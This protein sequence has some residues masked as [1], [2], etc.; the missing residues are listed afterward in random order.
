MLSRR[1][2]ARLTLWIFLFGLVVTTAGAYVRLSDA[3]LGCPDWPGCYGHVGV[4]ERAEDIARANQ[5]FERPVEIEKGWKEMYHRYIAGGLGL[6]ILAQAILAGAIRRRDPYQ[7]V[8]LPWLL[9]G[10]V[11]FQ[12]LLGMWTV[13]LQLKPLVVTGHLLMGFTTVA[14]LWWLSL[15]SGGRFLRSSTPPMGPGPRALALFALVVVFAQIALGGWVASNYAA[16]AC[17]DFPTCHGSWWPEADF[18]SAFVLWHGLGINYEYGILDAPARIA[19]QLV[20]RV[21]AVVTVLTVVATALVFITRHPAH[22]AARIALFS[23]AIVA[24]QFALGVANVLLSLPLHVAVAHNLVGALML[25]S[26]VALNHAANP[27][28]K[29]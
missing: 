4:P 14:A 2:Y 10:L 26:M 15:R 11:I 9:V 19:I 20:H 28:A 6:L 13:T 25:M 16:L 5:N 17:T 3:G 24:V 7:P 1:F 12:A 18:D 23:L 27:P 29:V 21:G 8:V 22:P